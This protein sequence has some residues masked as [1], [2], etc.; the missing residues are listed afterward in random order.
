MKKFLSCLGVV[1][2]LYACNKAP[3]KQ[4]A[5]EETPVV[6]EPEALS[7]IAGSY[8]YE[9]NGDTVSLHLTVNGETASGHLTYAL[10][11][12]DRNTGTFEG[13]VE[14]GVLLADYT[15]N[16]EGQSSVREVAF[17]LDGTSAVE[18]YG[19]ME[20]KNGKMLFKDASKLEYGKGMVLHKQ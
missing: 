11:E 15:F 6:T 16:S 17:R 9:Q 1:A 4:E 8:M 7:E 14:N 12:K 3:V 10:K 5:V 18:G 2:L 20:E 19:D 13:K